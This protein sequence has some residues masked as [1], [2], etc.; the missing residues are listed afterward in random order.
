MKKIN[1]TKFPLL[2][3]DGQIEEVDIA[4]LFFN[5]AYS[6]SRNRDDV[7]KNLS[8]KE[9]EDIELTDE[10]I[11]Y[12]NYHL[13]FIQPVTVLYSFEKYIEK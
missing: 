5:T 1:F 11:E 13:G 8:F 10:N 7:L 3:R 4:K 12:F 9:N 6:Q 2:N